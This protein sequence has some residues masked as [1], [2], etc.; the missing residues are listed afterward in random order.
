MKIV[1]SFIKAE[2]RIAGRA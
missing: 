1:G 2:T